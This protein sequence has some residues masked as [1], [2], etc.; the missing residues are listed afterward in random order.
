MTALHCCRVLANKLS[1]LL[2]GKLTDC[3]VYKVCMH[4]YVYIG[5]CVCMFI[6][7]RAGH[8]SHISQDIRN[9]LSVA[10]SET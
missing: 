5:M 10:N 9:D 2:D 7:C 8:K 3:K 6:S 1:V 4:R